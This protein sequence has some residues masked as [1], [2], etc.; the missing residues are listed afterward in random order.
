MLMVS[1]L[2]PSLAIRVTY[3]GDDVNRTGFEGLNLW[4]NDMRPMA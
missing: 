4:F 3:T 2:T 1:L